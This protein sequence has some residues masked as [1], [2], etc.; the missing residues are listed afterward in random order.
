MVHLLLDMD[1]TLIDSSVGV[2]H[3]F[4]VAC[5]ALGL[6][7]PDYLSFIHRIGP[8]V[9]IIAK[10]IFPY[11]DET[12]LQQFCSVFRDDYD[13]DSFLRLTWYPSTVETLRYLATLSELD[14]TLV[15]NKPTNPSQQ[16]I[17]NAEL[18]SCF[19]RVIGVDYLLVNF[20]GFR[21]PSKTQAIQYALQTH[22]R[23]SSVNIYVGDTIGDKLAC[24]SSRIQFIAA[25]YGFFQWSQAE[26][27]FR[28]INQFS[29]VL[30]HLPPCCL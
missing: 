12:Q 13:N 7:T 2:H 10:S 15:T 24:D 27:P 23:T 21:F 3:S 20:K 17:A 6:R 18:T 29:D 16:I 22:F 28:C 14:I 9:H 25:L 8:P 5:E 4:L 11:L 30:K 26:R 1:G 19:S